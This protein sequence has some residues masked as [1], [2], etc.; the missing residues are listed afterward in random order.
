MKKP[1]NDPSHE[2]PRKEALGNCLLKNRDH[3]QVSDLTIN[4]HFRM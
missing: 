1:I 2:T 4:L 3:L